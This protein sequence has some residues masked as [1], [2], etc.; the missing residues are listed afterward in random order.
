MGAISSYFISAKLFA[1][2][3]ERLWYFQWRWVR[4]F[5]ANFSVPRHVSLTRGLALIFAAV[6]MQVAAMGKEPQS[7]GGY[8]LAFADTELGAVAKVEDTTDSTKVVDF[9]L[10]EVRRRLDPN[11]DTEIV[12]LKIDPDYRGAKETYLVNAV[13]DA[14]GRKL[15]VGVMVSLK[16][17]S[18]G[19]QVTMGYVD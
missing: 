7:D 1:I 15:T 5:W 17:T 18:G 10:A 9:V 4:F 14:H 12:E 8:D 11:P 13:L 2:N 3:C 6:S 16:Q 19:L